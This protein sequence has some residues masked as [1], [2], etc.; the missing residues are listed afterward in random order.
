MRSL[1]SWCASRAVRVVLRQ[2]PPARYTTQV[3]Y[4]TKNMSTFDVK[5]R[6][7]NAIEPHT[8]ADSLEFAVIDDYRSLVRKGQHKVGDLVVYLPEACVT[9]PFVLQSVGLWD[10]VA[11]KGMCAGDDGLRV[12]AI[13]LRG[14]LSQGLVYPLSYLP[15]HL[16]PGWYLQTE[17]LELWPVK[18]GMEVSHLLGVHKYKPVI[19]AD[20]DGLV[21]DAGIEVMPKFDVE[22]IKKFPLVIQEGEQVEMTE[23][24]HGTFCTFILMP[25]GHAYDVHGDFIV[26]S[27]GLSDKGLAFQNVPENQGNAYI[28]AAEELEMRDKLVQLRSY[29]AANDWDVE[30]PLMVFG[31]VIGAASEQDLKY[32][33]KLAVAVFDVSVGWRSSMKYFDPGTVAEVAQAV[34]LGVAP[35]VYKGPFSKA[36]LEA[37][38]TG[39]E[40][41]SGKGLHIREGVVVRPLVGR[42][43]PELGRVILKS[44]S[45]KY[46]V[47]GG[48]VTEFS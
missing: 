44:V 24:L 42:R 19:P 9:T 11:N 15:E 36:V 26:S 35:L 46:L 40:T 2:E 27:K 41:Y 38:T 5:V 3:H 47:R 18:E 29:L 16:V 32:G 1:F 7:I 33:E 31:E 39:K 6:R 4:Q 13:K 17:T 8:N 43:D 21:F 10:A 37:A 22:D 25:E 14:R 34:G 23:K 48:A 28:R 12:K 30:E 20:L 45:E